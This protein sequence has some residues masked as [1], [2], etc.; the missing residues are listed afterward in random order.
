MLDILFVLV[1]ASEGQHPFGFAD[2]LY[3]KLCGASSKLFEECGKVCEVIK[4]NCSVHDVYLSFRFV[5]V[6][7]S[8]LILNTDILAH[9]CMDCKLILLV[10]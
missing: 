2:F 6:L 8:Y 7:L 4:V 10:F 9:L 5:S 3:G 1:S